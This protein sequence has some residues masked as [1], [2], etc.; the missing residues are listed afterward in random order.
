MQITIAE[1]LIVSFTFKQGQESKLRLVI[2]PLTHCARSHGFEALSQRTHQASADEEGTLTIVF[3]PLPG[4]SQSR[5]S[6]FSERIF[7][8]FR[9]AQ[10]ALST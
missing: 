10:L 3:S 6:I 7:H 4:E 2:E 9:D 8:A 5:I 1:S